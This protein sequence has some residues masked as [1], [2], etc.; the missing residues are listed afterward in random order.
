MTD[1]G[2]ETMLGVKVPQL[3]CCI[4]WAAVINKTHINVPTNWSQTMLVTDTTIVHY[5]INPLKC[6]GVR[7]LHFKVFSAIQV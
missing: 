5:L 6:S 2:A 4:F 1:E 3:D 7:Q